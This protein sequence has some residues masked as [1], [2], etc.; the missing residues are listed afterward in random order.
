MKRLALV[1]LLAACAQSNAS[2]VRE[3]ERRARAHPRPE[4]DA[5]IDRP[6]PV[7]ILGHARGA[8]LP[9]V[10]GRVPAVAGRV[11]GVE[12][13]FILDTGASHVALS[14]PAAREAEIYV[15]PREPVNM[16]SPG[17]AVSHRLCVFESLALGDLRFGPGVATLA[18]GDTPGLRWAGLGSKAFAIVGGT[19]LSRFRVTLDFRRRE[20]RLMPHGQRRPAAALWTAVKFNGQPYWVLVD[21]GATRP[22]LEP[23]AALELGLISK[24]RHRRHLVKGSSEAE[25]F[26]S[27][28]TLDSVE[29]AG[30]TFRNVKAAAVHTFGTGPV[31]GAR[32][33]AGL[34]GLQG[35]GKLVWTIDYGT[36]RITVEDGS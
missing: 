26:Y 30:R 7:P 11:N 10:R 13:P 29:V 28:F 17:Y 24:P 18:L 1:V 20:V 3:L 12:M 34:L 6:G 15:S 33:P 5:V 22:I 23:W 14:A 32:T 35:F 25:A 16:V 31:S 4:L 36:R 21:S 8:T 27:Q 9:L 19:V 2:A